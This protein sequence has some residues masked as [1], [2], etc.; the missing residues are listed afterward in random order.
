MAQELLWFGLVYAL[1]LCKIAGWDFVLVFLIIEV[2]GA[3]YN[4]NKQTL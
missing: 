2:T 3:Y 1:P 4:Q